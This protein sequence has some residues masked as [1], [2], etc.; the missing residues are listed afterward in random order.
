VNK[1][2]RK[3]VFYYLA[4]A[5]PN[6][7]KD[8]EEDELMVISGPGTLGEMLKAL[9]N[10]PRPNDQLRI[11]DVTM[12]KNPYTNLRST[13][14]SNVDLSQ[15][16]VNDTETKRYLSGYLPLDADQASK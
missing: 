2:I 1:K 5:H 4:T 8:E 13:F 14:F 16:D 12:T 6:Q 3:L 7:P 10:D 9:E 15:L 11:V